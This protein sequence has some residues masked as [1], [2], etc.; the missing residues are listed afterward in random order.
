MTSA[1][2]EYLRYKNAEN[3]VPYVNLYPNEPTLFIPKSDKKS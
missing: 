3:I 1:L 2:F